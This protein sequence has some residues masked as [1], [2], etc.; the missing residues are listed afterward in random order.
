[1][2][3]QDE[4]TLAESKQPR[5]HLSVWLLLA[6][7]IVLSAGI[8]WRLLDVPLERD[9][10]EY[11]YAGQL[12][13][14]GVPPYSRAYNMKLPGTYASYAVILALFGETHRGIHLGLLVINTA[15]VVL[16]FLLA[17][18]LF[19]NTAGVVAAACFAMLSL[20]QPLQGAFANSEHFVLLSAVAGILFL[21]RALNDGRLRTLI[22]AGLLLGLS[23]TMKQHGI[24]FVAFGG[25]YLLVAQSR[26]RPLNVRRLLGR[27][28]IL[29]VAAATPY[30]M[31]C[32]TLWV[33]G[34][35]EQ[36]WFWTVRYARTYVTAVPFSEV[37]GRLKGAAIHVTDG[38]RMIWLLAGL[39]LAATACSH[40]LRPQRAF[41]LLLSFFSLMTVFPGFAFRPHY[42]QLLLPAAG[43]L[44]AAALQFLRN[45]PP[46]SNR[47]LFREASVIGLLLTC[48]A[49]SIYQQRRYLFKMTPTEVV[50]STFGSNPFPESL[51]VAEYVR[52]HTDEDDRIAVIG[53]EPEIYF[54]ARRRGA[55]GYIYT[56]PL[57]EAHEFALVMQRKMIAQ[58]EAA[59]PEFIV[60]VSH[61]LS[62][63]ARP[64]SH[65]L[66]FEWYDA[67][68]RKDYEIVGVVNM[69]PDGTTFHWAP[70]V[71]W[72]PE[73]SRYISVSRRKN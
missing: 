22:C 30:L 64:G 70:E 45:L 27:V 6:L 8:R 33:A 63:V 49:V 7:V 46:M 23:F 52:Q 2:S 59:R 51:V 21:L 32:L 39:G 57:M 36:F 13:L 65:R 62:W 69:L 61:P 15:T 73:S 50:R 48:L 11:A 66:I 20:S 26:Q 10:G 60:L 68:T 54:Y 71:Q 72:P 4:P 58:I 29:A 31:T 1:M 47:R 56:Y 18:R 42:F 41:L 55:T 44:A 43:L 35:F 53:S 34:V 37:P 40:N 25:V 3:E 14:Q 16:V 17:Q 9:E 38:T 19:D 28:A 12:I 67:Y 24:A 5:R